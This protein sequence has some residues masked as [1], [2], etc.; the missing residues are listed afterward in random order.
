MI[1]FL[2]SGPDKGS[3]Y[4]EL[5]L[6][7]KRHL[8]HRIHRMKI[9]GNGARKPAKPECEPNFYEMRFLPAHSTTK[10]T[11]KIHNPMISS[12]LANYQVGMDGGPIPSLY[13]QLLQSSALAAAAAAAAYHHRPPPPPP[14]PPPPAL[15]QLLAQRPT[16][17]PPSL[18]NT[19][20]PQVLSTLM[21]EGI[22]AASL[23]NQFRG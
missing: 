11:N 5:F 2:A 7:N 14:P 20:P 21:K 12:N 18:A 15:D 3:H 10:N 8:A 13:A 9:K 1:I 6:R 19:L 17:V 22:E 23:L 16:W 4:H